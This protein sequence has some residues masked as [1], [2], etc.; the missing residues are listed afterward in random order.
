MKEELNYD[1]DFGQQ[2]ENVSEKYI[3]SI[4]KNSHCD[5]MRKDNV[6]KFASIVLMFY[7]LSTP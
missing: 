7:F 3:P 6:T 2:N 5:K 4:N 1:Y